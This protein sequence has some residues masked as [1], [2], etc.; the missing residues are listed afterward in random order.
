MYDLRV[1]TGC[2]P[3]PA[4]N[5]STCGFCQAEL[6]YDQCRNCKPL[7][8]CGTL[9]AYPYFIV[10]TVLVTFMILNVFIAILIESF[11]DESANHKFAIS[12]DHLAEFAALWS[13]YD[14][15]GDHMIPVDD[16]R[17][18]MKRL[19]EPMGFMKTVHMKRKSRVF[20]KRSGR[21]L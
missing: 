17:D 15:D 10:F 21:F 16:F 13:E 20:K 3:S 2:I 4:F 19:S 8:G 7:R 5:I 1:S 11:N 6:D 12:N 18:L 14:T 9:S